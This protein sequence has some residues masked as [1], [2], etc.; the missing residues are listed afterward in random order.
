MNLSFESFLAT[1]NVTLPGLLYTP[2]KP[3]KKATIWLHGMGDNGIFYKSALINA[4]AE[5]HDKQGIAFLAFNNRGAHSNKQLKIADDTL[6]EEDRSYQGGSHYELIADCVKDIDGAV[7]FL[8]E[9]GFTE[10]Y[11]AGH[12]TG[13]NKI[14]VYDAAV[15]QTPFKKYVFAGPGD[16][17]GLFFRDLGAKRY[18]EALK[19]AGKYLKKEPMRV[20]PKYSGMYPFSAQSAWDIL[21]PDGN[22]NTFPYYEATAERLGEKPLFKE[23]RAIE[24]PTLVII[25]EQDEYAAPAGPKV[26]LDIFMKHTSNAMLKHHDFVLVHDA[27]HSFHDQEAEF[28]EQVAEWLA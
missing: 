26:A 6:P 25:G 2:D 10:L 22:Y 1:D 7:R 14:C 18:W 19:L 21:N 17:T 5:A 4:L 11:L 20:M 9:K 24:N 3:T 15:E 27:D 13:A 23:Y 28:A 16:D 8:K 12:S